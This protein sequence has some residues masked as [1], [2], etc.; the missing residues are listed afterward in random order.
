VDDVGGRAVR[1]GRAG[2]STGALVDVG[3]AVVVALVVA[4]AVVADVAPGAREPDALAYL[5]AVGLGAPMLVR[6]RWPVA[7]ALVTVAMLML[8]HALDYPPVGV[9]VPVAAALYSVAESGR[10]R[11]AI[12]IA[13]GLISA[14]TWFRIREGDDVAYLFGI[15]LAASVT[16]M[17][18]VIVLG[19]DLRARRGWQAEIRRRAR[20]AEAEREQEAARRVEQERMR[21]ARE[22]H[23]VL[24]HTVSVISVQSDVASEALREDPGGAETALAAIRAASREA[25]GELRSTVGLLRRQA[26][27]EPRGP[28]PG[29]AQLDRIVGS[30]ADAG[31]AVAVRVDGRPVQLPVV[32]DTAAHRIVQESITN[33]LR[34]AGAARATVELRYRPEALTVRV[35]DDGRGGPAAADGSGFG[36]QGMR[37]RVALLGGDF[38]AGARPQGGYLVEASLPLGGRA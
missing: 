3:L 31:L 4:A 24:A 26:G 32:V 37:E 1:P 25:L 6:R 20:L 5:F 13:F 34:H 38:R 10:L 18:A 17:A 36:L 27:P 8:Y 35:T 30:A 9:A 23:D 28:V 15:E 14:S 19:D 33:V 11:W 12:G 21:I 2:G 7:T 29:L 16:L 22:L